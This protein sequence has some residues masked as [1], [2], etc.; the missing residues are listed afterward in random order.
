MGRKNTHREP[1]RIVTDGCYP[2]T[3]ESAHNSRYFETYERALVA[4][5]HSIV[6]QI[7]ET[8][9][10]ERISFERRRESDGRYFPMFESYQRH[11]I[12]SYGLD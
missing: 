1:F 12:E 8:A 2:R 7:S 9:C 5:T 6:N 10:V 11:T 4:Y 3:A